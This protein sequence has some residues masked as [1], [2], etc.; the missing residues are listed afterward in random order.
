MSPDELAK[1]F[2]YNYYCLMKNLDGISEEES[3]FQPVPG[4][5]CLN[6]VTGHILATRNLIFFCLNKEPVLEESLASRYKRGS[7]PITE[8][9][10]GLPWDDLLNLLENSQEQLLTTIKNLSPQ[11]LR[12]RELDDQE[13]LAEKLIGLHFH[14]AYHVGQ[15]GILRRLLGKEGAIH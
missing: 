7:E 14:E 3:F 4:G 5:N 15:T 2:Q 11:D 12:R 10:Q 8:P 13:T 1:M 9:Q 6:W